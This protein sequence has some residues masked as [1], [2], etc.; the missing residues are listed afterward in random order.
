MNLHSQSL[1]VVSPVSPPSEVGKVE[2]DLV[3]TFVKPHGHCADERFHSCSRLVVRGSEPP[4]DVLIVQN[5]DF[6]SEVLL[7]VFD[8]HYEERKLYSEG[9]LR[10]GGARDE[11][12]RDVGAHDFQD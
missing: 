5:L 11:G 3:P 6:E 4:P 8:D 12:R 1:D 2:L 7:Q 9:L 10:V